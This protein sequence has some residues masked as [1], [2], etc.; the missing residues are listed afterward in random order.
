MNQRVGRQDRIKHKTKQQSDKRLKKNE[1]KFKGTA[2]HHEMQQYSHY[3]DSRGEE[4]EQGIENLFEKIMKENFP[5]LMK[6]YVSSGSNKGPQS[7]RTQRGP[8]K[9]TA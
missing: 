3:R 2:E 1:D 4:R 8:L 9:D 7:R 5:N 6:S